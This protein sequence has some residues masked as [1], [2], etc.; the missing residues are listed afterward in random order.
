MLGHQM[1]DNI[2]DLKAEYQS[3]HV[4][5]HTPPKCVQTSLPRCLPEP[6]VSHQCH[7]LFPESE[8][9]SRLKISVAFTLPK[10]CLTPSPILYFLLKFPV[11]AGFCVCLI[12]PYLLSDFLSNKKRCPF[13]IFVMFTVIV[14]Q[15]WHDSLLYF[16]NEIAI[17]QNR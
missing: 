11:S 7:Y 4:T 15:V 14:L 2:C 9:G 8:E 17:S 1:I 16:R 12:L 6:E 13:T 10:C 5:G 3:L